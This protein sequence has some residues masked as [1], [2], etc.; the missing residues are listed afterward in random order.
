[1]T[2]MVKGTLESEFR[3]IFWPT[4]L[5]YSVTTGSVTIFALDSTCWANCLPIAICFSTLYQLPR[6]LLQP[7]LRLPM[8]S[9]LRMLGV[10]LSSSLA[11]NRLEQIEKIARRTR[12]LRFMERTPDSTAEVD[13]KNRRH[14]V[15]RILTCL[16]AGAE[17][18]VACKLLLVS[19]SFRESRRRGARR[20]PVGRV[21]PVVWPEAAG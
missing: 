13:G 2:L 20:S 10:G 18:S 15:V 9:M 11:A 17:H 19:A 21:A 16:E 6:P 1:M 3:T 5:T 8:A 7:T 12:A 14:N 4:R